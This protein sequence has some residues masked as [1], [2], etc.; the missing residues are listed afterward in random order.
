MTK[1]SIPEDLRMPAEWEKQKSTWIA[2]PHNKKDWPKRFDLIPEVFA[3][4]VFHISKNQMVNILIQ[5]NLLKKK[6]TLILRNFKV[7]FSNIKFT[8]GQTDRAWL[9]DSFPIFVKDSKKKNILINWNFNSW[10]KYNNFRKDNNIIT[11]IKK[12]G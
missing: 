1:F 3:E 10:A 7:N 11:K 12:K 4:I 6:A 8:L 9:R 5:N 2:W